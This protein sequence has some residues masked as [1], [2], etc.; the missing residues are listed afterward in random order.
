MTKPVLVFAAGGVKPDAWVP[1]LRAAA[2]E[3]DV[4]MAAEI[5]DPGAVEFGFAWRN[6]PGFWHAFPNLRAI[7][8][9]GAG[10]DALLSDPDLPG[11][12]P[13]I[14][15]VDPHLA[16]GMSEFAMMR[17]LHHHRSLHVYE[18]QQTA[19]LWRPIRPPLNRDRVVGVMGLGEMGGLCA[20]DLAKAGFQVRGWS[21]RPREIEGVRTYSGEAG[22]AE[23]ATGCEILICVLPL[24][25][26]TTG[27]LNA[28]LF[29]RLAH[30]ACL[31]SI[32]RGPHLVEADLLAALESGRI[33]A[34]TLDVFAVEPLPAGHPFWSHT[35][36]RVIP[37]AASF[38]FPETGAGVL[39]ENIR[40]ILRGEPVPETVDRSSGY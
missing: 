17:T 40:K 19:Q 6:P 26:E 16:I 4:R 23:F 15:M 7:F 39:A 9:M 37:H 8:G 30:G 28:A 18:Q 14:R 38:S 20:R 22:L 36:I 25:P 35:A 5:T 27:V 1:A 29:D 21:R 12:V 3:V 13:I 2:P 33:A 10:V 32:G 31:I 24:T 34:A 11:G